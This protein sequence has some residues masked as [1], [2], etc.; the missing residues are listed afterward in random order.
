MPPSDARI[1]ELADI[2]VTHAQD[3]LSAHLEI[4]RLLAVEFYKDD[5]KVYRYH[6]DKPMSLRKLQRHLE[7]NYDMPRSFSSIAELIGV[8]FQEPMLA[9]APEEKFLLSW[10]S[11][12]ALLRLHTLEG[13]KTGRLKDWK[14]VNTRCPLPTVHCPLPSPPANSPDASAPQDCLHTSGPL[15]VTILC[16]DCPLPTAHCPLLGKGTLE[17]DGN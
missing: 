12:V 4:G 16:S 13:W 6:S 9:L 5:L 11:R 10:S 8:H 17:M 3:T 2:I 14:T 15:R 1:R 7:T